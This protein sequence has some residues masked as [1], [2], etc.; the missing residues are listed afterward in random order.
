M[1]WIRY[2]FTRTSHY[3]LLLEA[4][5]F[6]K[7]VMEFLNIFDVFCSMHGNWSWLVSKVIAYKLY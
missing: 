3:E 5:R 6:E 7:Y 1:V 4:N 2:I